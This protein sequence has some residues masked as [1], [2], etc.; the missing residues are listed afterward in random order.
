M[1]GVTG[2]ALL[3][4]GVDVDA[5]VDP[6]VSNYHIVRYSGVHLV[7]HYGPSGIRQHEP[8]S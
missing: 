3:D 8:S 7:C 6:F 4:E 2:E 5:K 1:D